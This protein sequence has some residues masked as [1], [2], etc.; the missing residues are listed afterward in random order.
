MATSGYVMCFKCSCCS[1]IFQIH[2]KLYWGKSM[3]AE[4]WTF[5]ISK[6]WLE[7]IRFLGRLTLMYVK[8]LVSWITLCSSLCWAFSPRTIS[9]F[10][11]VF[12][13]IID[14]TLPLSRKAYVLI[15][16]PSPES[17]TWITEEM[18]DVQIKQLY[19]VCEFTDWPDSSSKCVWWRL[20]QFLHLCVGGHFFDECYNLSQLKKAFS[21]YMASLGCLTDTFL[22]FLHIYIVI[23]VLE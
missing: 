2:A 17:F 5:S 19:S 6:N 9:S 8:L 7:I 20:L 4:I 14:T 10:E 11:T 23:A 1:L 3:S 18:M 12:F 22:N 13:S 16:S 21:W 15:D